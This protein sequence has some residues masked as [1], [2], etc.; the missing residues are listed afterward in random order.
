MNLASKPKCRTSRTYSIN[1]S[2]NPSAKS[3]IQDFLKPALVEL[4]VL[5]YTVCGAGIGTSVILKSNV[6]KVLRTLD[7]EATVKAVSLEEA[8]APDSPAQVLLVTPELKSHVSEI[9]SEVIPIDNIFDLAE[10]NDK[11]AKALS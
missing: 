7:L 3:V 1:G 2:L 10:L 9:R 6:E 8:S 5:I 4:A 11:L